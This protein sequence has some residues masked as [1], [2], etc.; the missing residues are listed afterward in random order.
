MELRPK[1]IEEARSYRYGVWAGNESGRPYR[2]GGCIEEIPHN[3][4]S[5]LYKQ[6]PSDTYLDGA[7]CKRHR[8][9]N[10]K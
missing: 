6:C 3:R 7:F 4:G 5:F 1:T 10:H 8:K 2:E 9:R